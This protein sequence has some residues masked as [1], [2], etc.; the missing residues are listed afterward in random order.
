MRAL[1]FLIIFSLGHACFAEQKALPEKSANTFAAFALIVG[2]FYVGHQSWPTSEK[3]LRE[4]AAQLARQSPPDSRDIVPTVLS[5]MRHMEFTPRGKDVL[6]STRFREDGR[7]YS[8]A[9]I[10]HPGR[11]AEEIARRMTPQ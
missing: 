6:L 1:V 10:L 7:D 2:E 11:S 5:Y 9:A 3:Q 4:Y 8:Y